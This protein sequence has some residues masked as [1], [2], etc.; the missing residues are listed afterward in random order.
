MTSPAARRH[1]S[2]ADYLD[3]EE[4]SPAVKHELVDGGIF[5]MAGGTIEHAALS[6]AVSALLVAQ[7][8]GT[9]CRAYSSDLRIRIREASVGTYADAAVVCDPVERDLDSPTHVTNPRVVVESLSASTEDYD[10]NEKRIYYQMLPSL[11]EYILVAQD[12]RRVEVWRRS[13]GTWQHSVF[14]AGA[15]ASIPS[16]RVELDVNEI[17]DLAGVFV[18]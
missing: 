6:A 13:E 9:P 12:R 17:Y 7:L 2:F 5:A 15:Q 14:E 11:Q 1:H 8:R 18:P 4:M 10:R 3:V 16:I